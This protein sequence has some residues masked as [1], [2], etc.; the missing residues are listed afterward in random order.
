MRVPP[1]S[2]ALLPNGVVTVGAALSLVPQQYAHATAGSARGQ[3][4]G[5]S[6]AGRQ[7]RD[8]QGLV[9]V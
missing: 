9:K 8:R 3:R 7:G 4:R 1:H 5:H 6:V 2:V